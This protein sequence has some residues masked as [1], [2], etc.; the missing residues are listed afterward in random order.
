MIKKIPLE[1]S[2][3]IIFWFISFASAFIAFSILP[4]S[5]FSE[6]VFWKVKIGGVCSAAIVIFWALTRS[7]HKNMLSQLE[8]HMTDFEGKDS[9]PD[10]SSAECS[11]RRIGSSNLNK[12]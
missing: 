7:Y 2:V 1:A 10:V 11:Y 5:S 12:W 6:G 4:E 9:D 8:V 3:S